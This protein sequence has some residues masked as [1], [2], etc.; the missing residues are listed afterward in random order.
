MIDAIDVP[1]APTTLAQAGPETYDHTSLTVT[2]K[3]PLDTGCLPILGYKFQVYDTATS[4][5]V[6][7][8][9]QSITGASTVGTVSSLVSG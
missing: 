1:T 2:W 3:A 9:V 7:A 6:D 8:P 4:A 5:W